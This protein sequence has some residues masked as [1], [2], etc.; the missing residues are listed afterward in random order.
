MATVAD[1]VG[2]FASRSAQIGG[3]AVWRSAERVRIMAA[4]LAADLLEASPEDIRVSGGAFHVAGSE[5]ARVTLADVAA[6]AAARGVDLGSEERYSP[7]VQTFPYGVHVAVVEVDTST[8]LVT[9]R[10]LVAVDDVGNVLDPML[11]EGQL[12]GS[13]MQGVAAALFEEMRYTEDGQP[14]VTSF[15]DYLM[16][17]AVQY[18]RVISG[19]LASPA[20]S[21]PLGAKGAGE[22]GC[23]GMP[24]AILNATIDAL[25]PLGVEDLQIP[26]TPHKVWQAISAAARG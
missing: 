11:V 16:P 4:E 18:S 5:E 17:T 19:H 9:I 21:N 20:P 3:S 26:L 15:V 6:H 8:G 2:S 10:K 12:H 7:G 14:L 1:S 25:R 13:V 23:I 22:G 24:P